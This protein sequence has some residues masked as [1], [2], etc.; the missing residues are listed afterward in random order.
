MV[1]LMLLALLTPVAGHADAGTAPTATG[2][3]Y[4]G[5]KAPRAAIEQ[6]L[7][8][9]L[10]L[11][12]AFVDAEGRAVRLGDFFAEAAEASGRPAVPVVL[13]LGYYHCPQLC[14]TVMQGALEALAKSGA[15]R[16]DYRVVAVSIDPAETPADAATRLAFDRRYAD[17]A[18]R[19]A[20]HESDAAMPLDLHELV[21][22]SDAID[23]LTNRAGFVFSRIVD[24]ARSDSSNANEP[25]PGSTSAAA[26]AHASGFLVATPQGRISRYFLGVRHDP[27]ALRSA[28]DA[29]SGESIGS[30]VDRLV[31]LCAHL[32][33]TL[34][35]FSQAVLLA[36]RLLGI[37]L[38][39]GL[40]GW[41]WWNRKAS[42]PE[43]KT[44]A[45]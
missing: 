32:D 24:M 16:S 18:S 14:E 26:F 35:R 17:F 20:G 10:P 25:A 37:G 1:L 41:I 23:R 4:P 19:S 40:A 45:T 13:V 29:A 27:K 34:G 28:L 39:L 21:G 3:V 44:G 8:E 11:T 12:A 38:V 30:L 22:R 7:G 42:T 2:F 43:N 9:A 6:R 31:L 33:P 36:L 5:A 15:R